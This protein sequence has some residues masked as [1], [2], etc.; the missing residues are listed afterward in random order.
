MSSSSSSSDAQTYQDADCSIQHR[1]TNAPPASTSSLKR[2]SNTTTKMSSSD[3]A[4]ESEDILIDQAN[5]YL[6]IGSANDETSKAKAKMTTTPAMALQMD[7]DVDLADHMPGTKTNSKTTSKSFTS[8][9]S[10]LDALIDDDEEDDDDGDDDDGHDVILQQQTSTVNTRVGAGRPSTPIPGASPQLASK[11]GFTSLHLSADAI[12]P[13][14]ERSDPLSSGVPSPATT[15]GSGRLS[16]S[17]WSHA[18]DKTPDKQPR[19]GIPQ[20]HDSPATPIGS[21]SSVFSQAGGSLA[22]TSTSDSTDLATL[23]TRLGVDSVPASS[24]SPLTSPDV[25]VEKDLLS[26]Q[27]FKIDEK[28]DS[29]GELFQALD[30]YLAQMEKLTEMV[31]QTHQEIKSVLQIIDDR[32]THVVNGQAFKRRKNAIKQRWFAIQDRLGVLARRVK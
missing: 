25:K 26:I 32:Q 28:E 4:L 3:P 22:S 7:I 10:A 2:P 19:S 15:P 27:W 29:S 6:R 24:S 1:R 20:S 14:A 16:S 11:S 13:K 30:T 17:A 5:K 21:P 18:N 23:R 31:A 12:T 8:P 9:A